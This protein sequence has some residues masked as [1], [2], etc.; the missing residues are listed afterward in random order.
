[1]SWSGTLTTAS[2]TKSAARSKTWRQAKAEQRHYSRKNRAKAAYEH[3]EGKS[4]S[5]VRAYEA[6]QLAKQ[7]KQEE[8][9]VIAFLN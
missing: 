8:K 4:F 6:M 5:I 2:Q 9:Q 1:M 7:K 3:G